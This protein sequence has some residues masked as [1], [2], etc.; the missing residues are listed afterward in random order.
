MFLST[1]SNLMRTQP[2]V[3]KETENFRWWPRLHGFWRTLPNFN[4]YTVSSDPG[5][6]LADEALSVLMGGHASVVLRQL[7]LHSGFSRE[8]TSAN[9]L[10]KLSHIWL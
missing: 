9:M 6:D 4:P 8:P 2:I 1:Q 3:E 7:W 5:Q 10:A